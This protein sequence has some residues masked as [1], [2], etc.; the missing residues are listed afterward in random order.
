MA[1]IIARD[2]G[3]L[4]RSFLWIEKTQ[5]SGIFAKSEFSQVG[6]QSKAALKLV[7][8]SKQPSRCRIMIRAAA[9]NFSTSLAIKPQ[10]CNYPAFLP[11]SGDEECQIACFPE[12]RYLYWHVRNLSR[13]KSAPFQKSFRTDRL[14]KRSP[15][16]PKN[17]N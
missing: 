3:T 17:T 1:T 14:P 10:I 13:S 11:R 7:L 8:H 5:Y 15:S 6:I 12:M 16:S 2:T 4:R 9:I